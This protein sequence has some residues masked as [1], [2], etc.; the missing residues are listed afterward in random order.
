MH[1]RAATDHPIES[2]FADRWSPRAFLPRPIEADRLD[3]LFEAAR[4]APSSANIQPWRFI[5][6]HA[7]TKAHDRMIGVL[8]ETN[9]GWAKSAGVLAMAIARKDRPDG[10]PNGHA[11]YDL[12]Q[13]VAFL[14]LQASALGL[15]THQMGGFDPQAAQ[16][17]F[18]I[19]PDHEPVTMIAIGYQADPAAL[20]DGLRERELMPRERQPISR[21]AFQDQWVTHIMD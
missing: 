11:R 2:I 10:R 21:F 1:K 18:A 9:A 4:W 20:P 19:P 15:V 14:V 5:Y 17:A 8:N 16:D 3:A 12:G 13:S 6:A 7:G